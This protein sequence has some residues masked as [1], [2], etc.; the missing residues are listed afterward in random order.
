MSAE[1]S[2]AE[3]FATGTAGAALRS[4]WLSS[5]RQRWPGAGGVQQ[6]RR[7]GSAPALEPADAQ[8]RVDVPNFVTYWL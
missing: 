2:G 1:C 7:D 4:A 3:S 8:Q 5:P 6:Q